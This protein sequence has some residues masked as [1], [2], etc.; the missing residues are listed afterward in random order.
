MFAGASVALLGGLL[1]V[2]AEQLAVR[3]R[4]LRGGFF[5]RRGILEASAAV[6]DVD[7]LCPVR[8][9]GDCFPSCRIKHGGRQ[10][11]ARFFKQFE[12]ARIGVGHGLARL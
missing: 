5:H 3:I 10:V 7:D 4:E 1:L 12:F 11:A 6:E 2:K 9:A 8:V